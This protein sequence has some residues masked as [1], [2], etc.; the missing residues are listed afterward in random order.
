MAKT[1]GDAA[2]TRLLTAYGTLYRA[3]GRLEKMGLRHQPLGGS[4]CAR[5]RESSRTQ[6]LHAHRARRS[7]G[8]RR[9]TRADGRSAEARAPAAGPRMNLPLRC[10]IALVRGWTR[11][12]T[13]GLD[14]RD[15]A[16]PPRRDRIGSLGVSRGRAAETA[17]RPPQSRCTWCCVS[18]RGMPRRRA[19]ARRIRRTRHDVARGVE[20]LAD[21]PTRLACRRVSRLPD[22][23][24]S[25][26]ILRRR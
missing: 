24:V 10:A 18:S 16:T 3:L 23:F 20:P 1:L 7:G 21:R 15:E 6:A 13:T 26:H 9:A 8:R 14:P 5:A 25:R 2:D 19:V 17:T 12:Y 22:V 11:F 4:R